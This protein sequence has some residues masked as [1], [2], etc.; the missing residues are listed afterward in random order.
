MYEN[1]LIFVE[2]NWT[3]ENCVVA[4]KMVTLAE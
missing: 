3:D 2:E 1:H 4:Q